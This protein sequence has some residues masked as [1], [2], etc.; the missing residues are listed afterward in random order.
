MPLPPQRITLDGYSVLPPDEPGWLRAPTK[1]PLLVLMKRGET[2]DETFAFDARSI[3]LKPFKDVGDFQRLARAMNM[4]KLPAARFNILKYEVVADKSRSTDCDLA[5]IVAEDTQAVKRTTSV[6]GSMRLEILA[7]T[8]VQPQ[9][10]ARGFLVSYS[11]RHY[12]EFSKPDFL[13]LAKASLS[14]V[15]VEPVK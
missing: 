9:D 15:M 10:K 13:G 2:A 14:A 1:M 7:L 3:R 8:C 4:E 6:K 12:P 5:H 11:R